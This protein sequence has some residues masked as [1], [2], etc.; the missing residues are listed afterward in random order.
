MK[1]SLEMYEKLNPRC[2]IEHEGVRMT[3]ATPSQL[4]RWRVKSIYTKKPWTLEWIAPFQRDH[5]LLDC[6][7][8][9]GT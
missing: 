1:L 5:L 9:V 3:S 7:A 8:K 2:E 6:I 4:T